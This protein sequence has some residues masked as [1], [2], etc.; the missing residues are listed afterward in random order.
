MSNIN[1]FRGKTEEAIT[2]V[3]QD[4]AEVKAKVDSI[5]KRLWAIVVLLVAVLAVKAPE[6][7]GGLINK[8]LAFAF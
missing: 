1:E 6:L 5:D 4:V 8:V 3:K 7:T 2:T